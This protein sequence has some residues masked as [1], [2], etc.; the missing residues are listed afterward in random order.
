MPVMFMLRLVE[1]ARLTQ[2]VTEMARGVTA[3]EAII[4]VEK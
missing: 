4:V 2:H 1:M 3:A